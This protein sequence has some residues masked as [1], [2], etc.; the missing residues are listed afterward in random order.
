MNARKALARIIER[1]FPEKVEEIRRTNRSRRTA[2]QAMLDE[3]RKLRE[4]DLSVAY[5]NER[6]HYAMYEYKRGRF[7]AVAERLEVWAK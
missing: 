6:L 4:S 7:T 5:I 1:M 3:S 2:M